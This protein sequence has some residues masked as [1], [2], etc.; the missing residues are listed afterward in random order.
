MVTYMLIGIIPLLFFTNTIFKTMDK[1]FI[2]ERKKEL[3]SQANVVSGH[4]TISNYMFDESKRTLFDYDIAQ[5]SKQ[6]GYR[7]LV[8][9]STGVVIND[10]NKTEVGKTYLI[11]EVVEALDN[12]DVSREQENGII[13]TAVSIVDGN[14]KKVGAV[15]ISANATDISLTLQGIQKQ[16][17]LLLSAIV[18]IV[19][20]VIFF[21]SQ[22]FTEPLKSMLEVIK[23][24]SEGHLDQRV[25][26]SRHSHNE[27]T[28]LAVA[29]NNMAEKL[30]TVENGRQ[31][32]VSNVS[33]ELKTPLSSIKVLSESILFEKDVPQETYVEFLRDINSEVDRMT[34]IINDLLTLVRLNQKEIP[35]AFKPE[36]LN[37]LVEE[38]I[39]RLNP[40]AQ[41]KDIE[42][43]YNSVKDVVADIDSMKLTLAISNL[44]ENAVKYTF[45][46][47]RVSV[48]VDADHQNA[49]FT[50]ADTGVGI[51]EEEL[52]RIFERFYRVD[53]TR[54]R[55]TGGT[56]L[57][58]SI[59]HST[60]LL[61]NGSIKVSSKEEEGTTFVVR[62]PLHQSAAV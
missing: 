21:L 52:S 61:H 22:I 57:G 18:L 19:L 30:E 15:L 9:D 46:G 10:S 45:D 16:V 49:F 50:I 6:S 4:I 39:K 12:K 27:I 56:G 1:Y 7:I 25:P 59:T 13:Y 32:F 62:I 51:A 24:M 23:K 40:L 55:E 11:P 20:V 38:I 5:T 28:D 41:K 48:T 34:A 60:V 47:G 33:H 14:S 53:K 58:L 37:A 26:I 44:I 8:I 43:E 31:E 36:N 35:I 2:D 29:C 42:I 3:L 54:D 17:Y